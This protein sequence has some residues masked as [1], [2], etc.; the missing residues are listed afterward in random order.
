MI[1]EQKRFERQLEYVR[2]SLFALSMSCYILIGVLR[3][4][5]AITSRCDVALFVAISIFIWFGSRALGKLKGYVRS[6]YDTEITPSEILTE[7]TK[8]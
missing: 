1:P 2:Y 3:Y 6:S 4:Y 5:K 8:A 7:G